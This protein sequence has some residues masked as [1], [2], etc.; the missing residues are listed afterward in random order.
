MVGLGPGP[1]GPFRQRYFE[2]VCTKSVTLRWGRTAAE[3][4]RIES[5]DLRPSEALWF[6]EGAAESKRARSF[7]N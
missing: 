2:E 5:E 7:G 6:G 3:F 1:R 4:I